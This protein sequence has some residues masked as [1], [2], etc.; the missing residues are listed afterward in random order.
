VTL[1]KAS[2]ILSTT[3][4]LVTIP[5]HVNPVCTLTSYFFILNFNIIFVP[6]SPKWFRFFRLLAYK[7]KH[8]LPLACVILKNPS[9]SETACD[10]SQHTIFCD[11][12]LRLREITPPFAGPLFSFQNSVGIPLFRSHA[13]YLSCPSHPPPLDHSSYIYREVQ[14]TMLLII[15]VRSGIVS[16]R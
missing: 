15:N 3:P 8:F 5:S 16:G 1:L 2:C 6:M 10:I 9:T 7:C 12:L 4:L 11:K 13:C 14:V